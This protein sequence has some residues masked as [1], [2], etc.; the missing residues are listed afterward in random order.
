MADDPKEERLGAYYSRSYFR[1]D[2]PLSDD[3]RARY[4]IAAYLSEYFF[5]S[6]YDVGKYIE[7]E[8]GIKCLKVVGN[9]HH[10]WW[11]NFLEQLSIA[12]FLDVI[13]ATIKHR[14]SK[15]SSSARGVVKHDL[16]SFAQRVFLEQNLSYRID[17][18]GGIHPI[19]DIAFVDVTANLLRSLGALGLGATCEHIKRAEKAL[20]LS[21]YDPRQAIRSTFDAAENLSKVIFPR[22]T[23]LNTQA[24][25]EKLGPYLIDSVERNRTEK[26]ASEKLVK[27]LIDWIEA[28]HFYRHAPG[29]VEVDQPTESFTIA[30]VSQGFSYVR[31][32]A[33]TYANQPSPETGKD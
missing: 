14:P 20:L 28:A 8:L 7:K 15:T 25:N 5:D 12:D 26:Q 22:L 1:A 10:I 3:A 9:R 30:F 23:Q 4:R 17:D 11:D 32:I 33:D 16:L 2:A 18:K 29:G 27:S 24:I 31:W 21:S 6:P 19:V 13:T